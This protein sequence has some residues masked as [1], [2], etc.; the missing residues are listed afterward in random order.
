MTR[1]ASASRLT[2]ILVYVVGQIE[3]TPSTLWAAGG[4]LHVAPAAAAPFVLFL[5][6]VAV[7]PLVAA[8][9]GQRNRSRALVVDL[10]AISTAGYL[11][12][13]GEPGLAA[14]SHELV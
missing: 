11:L 9:W 1:S 13:H 6:A 3:L 8:H 12:A 14:L 2:A 4:N 5:L 7:L 10:L